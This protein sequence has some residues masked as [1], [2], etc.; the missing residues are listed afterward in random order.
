M[1]IWNVLLGVCIVTVILAISIIFYSLGRKGKA[2]DHMM[3]RFI[4]DGE[5]SEAE[6]LAMMH[7]RNT[8]EW[9]REQGRLLG[10]GKSPAYIV[11]VLESHAKEMIA[12][13]E[14][15]KCP[16]LKLDAMQANEESHPCREPNAPPTHTDRQDLARRK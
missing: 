10:E 2:V 13:A 15:S 1:D 12:E 8:K 5:F 4:Q 3:I 6:V 16:T 9:L 11:G 7:I 14:Q